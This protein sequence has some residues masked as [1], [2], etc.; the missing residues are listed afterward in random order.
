MGKIAIRPPPPP[1]A[2]S[3]D[4]IC[5]PKPKIWSVRRRGPTDDQNYGRGEARHAREEHATKTTTRDRDNCKRKASFVSA[6]SL[7]AMATL[8]P[9][10]TAKRQRLNDQAKEKAISALASSGKL[11]P[12][13]ENVVVQLQSS[14]DG[15]LLGPSISLP[16]GN[17]GQRELQMIVN[18]LRR[19]LRGE[20]KGRRDDEES[21][22]DDY[23]DDDEDLPF[24][25]HLN[26]ENAANSNSPTRLD[27][28]T[29]ISQD[30]LQAALSRK[31]D[32]SAE[33]TL[34]IVFEP[35]AVFKVRPVRRCSSTMSGH[36]SPILYSISSPS[37]SLF[38]TTSGDN[39][40]RIWDTTSEQPLHA[41]QGHRNWVLTAAWD[42]LERRCAT[43][44]MDG[45]IWLW[46]A[47]D[48]NAYGRQGWGSKSG[49]QVEEEEA[50]RRRA[51]AGGDDAEALSSTPVKMKAAEKRALRH[52]APP[53]R[54][55]KGH[56]KWITSLAF[57]PAHL[58]ATSPRLASSS[59]DGT[60]RVWNTSTRTLAF[61]LASHSSSVN[62]VRWGGESGSGG[63]GVLY[64][65]ANDRSVKIW[66]GANGR[67]IRSL[68][69]HAHWVNTLAL[70]TD[71][72]LRS[73]AWD[74][75]KGGLIEGL[76]LATSTA[77]EIQS[78]ALKRFR[79]FV[80]AQ[81]ETLVSGSEDHSLFF[82]PPQI[83]GDA[84]KGAEG[85]MTPKKPLSRMVGHQKSVNHVAFSP[86]GR[87]IA[88]AS[89][90]GSV[91][92]WNGRDGKFVATL[93]GHVSSVYR[94]SWSC[95][96]RL[97]V[98]ASKDSTLKVWNLKNYKIKMDLPGHGDEVY[99]VDFVGDKVASGGRDRVV[100]IWRS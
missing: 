9:V 84:T 34:R 20:K 53:G 29:S 22:D 55:L 15:E 45:V 98:S 35:Q 32:L 47:I 36:S 58:N 74:E 46:D 48:K 61:T 69:S 67:L 87:L 17:T 42:P 78:A 49:K 83:G 76:S 88:S 41:L 66:D 97:L 14:V 94:L 57:E 80:A 95:D 72:L 6:S 93:R 40:A 68:D 43:G 99:C 79:K 85:G 7:S 71:F 37:S 52:A 90:D 51:A 31:L 75:R 56:T 70:S 86:D 8:P 12:T 65:A 33:D 54:A 100:K 25:F 38:L 60:V 44:D 96:S 3:R 39:T 27:I 64:T 30:V 10:P 11:N 63:G 91:R 18:Q 21:D 4:G 1:L 26:V 16:A 24:A 73:G 89:F 59:K 81:P 23:D 77:D 62:V 28:S 92:L 5:R 13:T 2:A 50:E 82:W 19:Q